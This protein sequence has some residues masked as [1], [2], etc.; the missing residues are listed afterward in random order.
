M[1]TVLAQA[2]TLVLEPH[3]DNPFKAVRILPDSG[4]HVVNRTPLDGCEIRRLLKA[5]E[6][7]PLSCDLIVAGLSTGLR[8]GDVCRLRWEQVDLDRGAL[9]LVTA[10]TGASLTLPV[11]PKLREV[12]QRRA[13][14]RSDGCAHVFPEAEAL[15]RENPGGL[16]WRVKKSSRRP[17]RR[18]GSSSTASPRRSKP[19]RRAR[20]ASGSGRYP[21][22]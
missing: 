2:F 6:S 19:S 12:L 22:C 14:L 5:A 21:G 13:R 20:A 8:R 4:D 16:T 18:P 3:S 7:D 10:K 9:R 1:K 17:S 15:L 11:L